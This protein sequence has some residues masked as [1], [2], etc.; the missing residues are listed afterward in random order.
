MRLLT[1]RLLSSLLL[2]IRL[3][4]MLLLFIRLLT[5]ILLSLGLL[6]RRLSA[7]LLLM[8][9]SLLRSR[10]SAGLLRG[11]GHKAQGLQELHEGG[12]PEPGQVGVQVLAPAVVV[13]VA[14]LMS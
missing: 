4:S 6:V 12:L 2:F 9:G 10:R 7:R 8:I 1:M 14:A 5:G 13:V 11:G 3:L